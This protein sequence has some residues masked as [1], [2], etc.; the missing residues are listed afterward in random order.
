[1]VEGVV[2]EGGGLFTS[3]VAVAIGMHLEP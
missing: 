3:I 1:M 2:L